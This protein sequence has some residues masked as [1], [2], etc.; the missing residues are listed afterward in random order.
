MEKIGESQW[1]PLTEQQFKEQKH[2]GCT[3]I[4]QLSQLTK[5]LRCWSNESRVT[6]SISQMIRILH[7]Y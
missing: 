4:I 1:H 5:L 2:M 6:F 3:Q 7:L